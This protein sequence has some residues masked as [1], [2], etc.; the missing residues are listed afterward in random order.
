[1]SA[2]ADIATP[3]P[4]EWKPRFNPWL[5][6][7]SI[8][9]AT[10]M[11]VLDTTIA[12]VSLPYIAGNLSASTDEATWVLTS[13]LAANAI[14]LPA[15]GWLGQVFG[16][17]RFL[18]ACI[19]LFTLASALC[20]LAS[21]L[22]ML[23]MTRALQGAAGG[24][25]QPISQ[26]VLLE[27]FPPQKR[28]MAMAVF[29]VGIVVAPILGPTIGGW[30][31]YNYSWRWTF[32]INLP[33][34]ILATVLI[35]AFLEDP[36]YL[37]RSSAANIDYIGFGLLTI[38]VCSLQAML[39]KGQD[40]DWF[41]S[42]LIVWCA[43]ISTVGFIAFIVRELVASSPLVDLR[44]L[45]NRNFA[46]GVVLI[47]LVGALLYGTNTILPLFMQNLLNY[48]ALAAGVAITPRGI[49]AFVA[50]II[51][52]RLVGHVSNRVLISASSV[53][54]ACSL[55]MLGDINLQ[56]APNSLLWPI[57]L[58][59]VSISAIFVPLTTSA[60]GTLSREQMGTATGIFNLVRNLGGSIG[61]TMIT[62]LVTR[63][64][65]ASQTSIVWHM[66]K[67]NFNFQEHF[68]HLQSALTSSTGSWA[69]T[70]KSL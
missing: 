49:G 51:V 19:I 31:T 23:I 66:S 68:A 56:L 8:M 67:L 52:G 7:V 47:F 34:G 61:I 18:I 27:S 63:H 36:P 69:A 50:T 10:V 11:E 54:L 59:G 20:G 41:G 6:A 38:W 70:K 29:T 42:K 28:G 46:V 9:L 3:L 2:R 60:M 35:R 5:I 43:V 12:S 62:T 40:L 37:K 57:V 13:Y 24:A 45:K 65:Q 44:V 22:G 26:A 16:R 64:T 55:F 1:M 30:L 39:D 4:N 15:T 58:S 53:L 21:S 48:T 33:I 17:K 25:L 14:I 32:Y